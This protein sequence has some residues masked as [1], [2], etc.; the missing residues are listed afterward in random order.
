MLQQQRETLAQ[1]FRST[2][3]K[4]YDEHDSY[5]VMSIKRFPDLNKLYVSQNGL[6]NRIIADFL[7]DNFPMAASPASSHYRII[8]SFQQCLHGSILRQN[9]I[10]V[11]DHGYDVRC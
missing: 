9:Q 5:I 3:I 10:P 1:E 11:T 6:T 4:T 8:A 7:P 2:L